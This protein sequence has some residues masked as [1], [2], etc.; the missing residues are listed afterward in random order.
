MGTVLARRHRHIAVGLAGAILVA[1]AVRGALAAAPVP[2]PPT[3]AAPS[4]LPTGPVFPPNGTN[5][6]GHHTSSAILAV[7]AIK[8]AG[9]AKAYPEQLQQGLTPWQPKRALLSSRGGGGG[10][11]TVRIDAGGID[12]LLNESYGSIAN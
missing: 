10:G 2:A 11:A 5:T 1:A 7:E 8:I 9:D 3:A 12:P 6:H 4:P